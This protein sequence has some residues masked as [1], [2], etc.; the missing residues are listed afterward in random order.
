MLKVI[1]EYEGSPS[2]SSNVAQF[3]KRAATL[4]AKSLHLNSK[5]Q[6]SRE[7]NS[8]N[9]RL[10]DATAHGQHSGAKMKRLSGKESSQMDP[11]TP[12]LAKASNQG[13]L[14]SPA[15]MAAEEGDSASSHI[16][17]T[18]SEEDSFGSS[19]FADSV[20]DSFEADGARGL[21]QSLSSES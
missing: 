8:K 20:N 7:D 10:K 2:K 5:A 12:G 14:G 19:K 21:R 1:D 17:N 4:H 6:L 9:E 18:S 13:K 16:F 11:G 3:L 15:G